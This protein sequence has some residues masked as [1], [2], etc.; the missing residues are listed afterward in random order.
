VGAVEAG[1]K[2]SPPHPTVVA[3]ADVIAGRCPPAD[4]EEAL[5][6]VVGRRGTERSEES[7]VSEWPRAER[8]D[9]EQRLVRGLGSSVAA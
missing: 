9:G 5:A 3:T 2:G 1:R 8:R 4:L 7:C 6:V